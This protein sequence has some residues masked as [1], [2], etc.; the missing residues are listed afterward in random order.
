MSQ[1]APRQG[2]RWVLI[3]ILVAA[4]AA[5]GWRTWQNSRIERPGPN[6]PVV[7]T[8][9]WSQRVVP[10]IDT[11]ADLAAWRALKPGQ[12]WEDG[13]AVQAQVRRDYAA[14]KFTLSRSPWTIAEGV[15]MIGPWNSDQLIYLIDT[16]AGLVL[17][18][19][20]LDAYQDEVLAQIKGLGF[21]PEQVRWVVLSHCHIDHGQS[22]QRWKARGATIIVGAGDAPELAACSDVIAKDFL[23]LAGN[24]CTPCIADRAVR[25]GEVLRMGNLALHAIGSAGHTPGSTSYAF[26]RGGKWLLLSG[27]ITLHNGRHAWMGGTKADCGQYLASLDRLANWR[28]DGRPVRFDLLLPGHGTIDLDQ[29]QR[30]VERTGMIVREIVARRAA[31]EKLSL[32]NDYRWAWQNRA[33]RP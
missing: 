19:P 11:Y 13:A 5:L 2:R 32:I 1:T 25:D 10:T 8:T 26:Q 6:Q 20:S 24:R 15:W 4:I 21:R 12:A 9:P 3:A 18:D 30:S 27:D 33:I 22:C 31:G 23:P 28:V 14:G 7:V 17:V 16:G 29:G